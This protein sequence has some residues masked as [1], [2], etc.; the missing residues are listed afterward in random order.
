MFVPRLWRLRGAERASL[1]RRAGGK[2]ERGDRVTERALSVS[3]WAT[4]VATARTLG[5]AVVVAAADIV[6]VGVAGPCDVDA[7]LAPALA[8]LV[9]APVT[10][11]AAPLLP[12]PLACASPLVEAPAAPG[13]AAPSGCGPGAS[14]EVRVTGAWKVANISMGRARKAPYLD[15]LE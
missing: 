7:A 14:P 13:T 5:E 9:L 2:G 15:S 10:V 3:L 4:V 8:G 6:L 11:T 12:L 1:R